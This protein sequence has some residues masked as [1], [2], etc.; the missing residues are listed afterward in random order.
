[1]LPWM[2]YAVVVGLLIGLAALAFERSAHV[3]RKPAR[4][5]WGLGIIASLVI[6]FTASRVSVQIPPAT[7]VAGPAAPEQISAPR[8]TAV[9]DRARSA[10]SIPGTGQLPASQGVDTLLV[11]AWRAASIALAVVIIASAAHLSWRR[12]RWGRGHMAG[13]AIYLSEDSG[14][15]VVGFFRPRIV[16]PR[17]LTHYPPG[18]QELVIAHEQCHLDANDARLLIVAVCLVICMPWNPVLWWQ[19]RR[20]RLAIEIDCDA[21][22]LSLGYPVAR[23]GETLIAVGERQSAGHA[24]GMA[25]FG[26]RS[27]LERR[28]H[29][30]LRTK[31]RY[32]PV[33]VT[34]LACLGAGL[35]VCAAEVAPPQVGSADKTAYQEVAIDTKLLDGYVGSYRYGNALLLVTRD[36]PQ[37][38][39]GPAGQSGSPIYPRSNTEFFFKR[40]DAQLSFVTDAQ[41][42]AASLTMHRVGGDVTMKRI[43]AATVQQIASAT[44]E[45][46]RTRSLDPA[47]AAILSRLV[48]GI[49]AGKPNTDDMRSGLA[50]AVNH[51]LS[52]LQSVVAPL[53]AVQSVQYLGVDNQGA[54]VYTVEQQ[55]GVS[56]WRVA[57]DATGLMSGAMV[58][59]GQHSVLLD[60]DEAVSGLVLP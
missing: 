12:R 8:Q 53:G 34:T 13:T 50:T 10:W 6:P 40:I 1:M 7:S 18:E 51:R 57:L 37:L 9:I 45:K 16:V 43:D 33:W 56:H 47:R 15:A 42:Q 39:A 14:P 17:W 24:M 19:L 26:S 59:P 46:Q 3:R 44:A 55:H 30:M 21:R 58:T 5:L 23:Y 25:R 28:I 32:A 22:V 54:D 41:G 48:D 4:L 29:T 52:K 27:F 35:V 31:T 2:L 11:T 60:E 49:V 36:G 20:L 38:S